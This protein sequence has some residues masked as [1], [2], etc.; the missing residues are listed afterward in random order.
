MSDSFK[1]N[2]PFISTIIIESIA[3]LAVLVY[4][5]YWFIPFVILAI[6]SVAVLKE[7]AWAVTASVLVGLGFTFIQEGARQEQMVF[8]VLVAIGSLVEV[9]VRV[10]QSYWLPSTG[11]LSPISINI[12]FAVLGVTLWAGVIYNK[13]ADF[14]IS[15]APL[16][17]RNAIGEAA[18]MYQTYGDQEADEIIKK[19]VGCASS[20][21]YGRYDAEA[22]TREP[23]WGDLTLSAVAGFFAR[24]L[25]I[26]PTIYAVIFAGLGSALFLKFSF[27]RWIVQSLKSFFFLLFIGGMGVG[28][29]Q[30]LFSV[31]LSMFSN[32]GPAMFSSPSQAQGVATTILILDIAAQTI[33]TAMLAGA[34]AS[35]F[36]SKSK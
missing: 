22:M 7:N 34:G 14:S 19:Y 32:I 10:L 18:D 35:L 17:I 23:E 1:K 15:Q 16:T 2:F 11:K 21:A 24:L 12:I 25:T 3:S 36:N 20:Y 31:L 4:L 13:C 28:A 33:A 30:G 29:V 6:I 27:G 26:A 5:R 9:G 8:T